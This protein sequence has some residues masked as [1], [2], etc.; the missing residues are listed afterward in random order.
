MS[1]T[2]FQHRFALWTSA[3]LNSFIVVVDCVFVRIHANG[4]GQ[5]VIG[6]LDAI[7]AV[8]QFPA[9]YIVVNARLSDGPRTTTGVWVIMLALNLIIWAVMVR[10]LLHFMFPRRSAAP[11]TRTEE[12][13]AETVAARGPSRRMFLATGT[14]LA[15]AGVAGTG[16]YSVFVGSRWFETTHRIHPLHGL[17]RELDGL[18]IVQL[19]D[20]HH[21]PNLSLSYVRE[22]VAATNALQ[23]DLVLLTGD[24]VHRSPLY[25]EPVARVLA[26]LRGRIGVLGVLG[27]HDWWEDGPATKRAFAHHRIPL[28]DNDR[29]FV[30]PQRTLARSA[31]SGLCI[32]GVGDY[33]EDQVLFDTALGGV[34]AGMPRV[35]L[36]HN[37]DVAEDARLLVGKW[38]VD[39]MMC[40]HT[41]GGQVKLPL[42]GTPIIPSRY[43]QKYAS[44]LVQGPVCPVFVSRGVGMTVLPVRFNV[45]P[46]V[47]V[48][49]LRCA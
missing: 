34:P 19:T 7:G 42:L 36:S 40:G 26:E 49:E 28:I 3:L 22:V 12:P 24:Y 4:W 11:Q 2:R 45:A 6:F 1:Q 8:L 37:P 41:H 5:P 31:A 18:R 43:G 27:N 29:M 47:A 35:L 20:I 9:L 23:A 30:T 14:R 46:E 17:P 15:V 33:M 32:A 38:R 39:L 44:G 25:I 16:I 48:I 13:T 10:L 21:G